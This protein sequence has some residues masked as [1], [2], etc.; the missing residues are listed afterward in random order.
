MKHPD[1]Q[2]SLSLHCKRAAKMWGANLRRTHEIHQHR[3]ALRF[4]GAA[5]RRGKVG[6]V[7]VR[8]RDGEARA[9]DMNGGALWAVQTENPKAECTD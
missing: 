2:E 3:T 4:C 9:T 5:R 7:M 8:L 1:E 6:I